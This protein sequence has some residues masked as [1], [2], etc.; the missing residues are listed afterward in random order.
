[1]KMKWFAL[2]GM[3]LFLGVAVAP[4]INADVQE[5][6]IVESELIEERFENLV[7]LVE[8]IISYVERTYGPLPD[9]DCG[10]E[11]EET[12]LWPFPII[13]TVIF[14]LNW[15][16]FILFFLSRFQIEIRFFINIAQDFGC[17]WAGPPYP[18]VD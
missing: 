18:L 4:S 5:P 3:V 1:M 15:P 9:E 7:G 13:C 10:C 6:D 16:F 2:L 11:L 12:N 8:G 14:I 17:W